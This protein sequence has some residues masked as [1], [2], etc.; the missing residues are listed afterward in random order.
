MSG[1]STKRTRLSS[2]FFKMESVCILSACHEHARETEHRQSMERS[3][4]QGRINYVFEF[5]WAVAIL[6]RTAKGNVESHKSRQMLLDKITLFSFCTIMHFQEQI[7]FCSC[8]WSLSPSSSYLLW[9]CRS[10][11]NICMRKH[12]PKDHDQAIH[13]YVRML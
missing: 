4:F 8:L 5:V 13:T 6:L 3:R 7:C 9:R 12:I 10:Y 1:E 2:G 11:L